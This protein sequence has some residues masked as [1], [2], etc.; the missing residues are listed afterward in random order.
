[1]LDTLPVAAELD[2]DSAHA[3]T[4][5]SMTIGRAGARRNLRLVLPDRTRA[6]RSPAAATTTSAS[7]FHPGRGGVGPRDRGPPAPAGRGRRAAVVGSVRADAEP[8]YRRRCG[9]PSASALP[10]RVIEGDRTLALTLYGAAGDVNWMRY[11]RPTPLVRRMSWEQDAADEVTLTLELDRPVWG[12]RTRWDGTTSCSTSAGLPRSTRAIRSVGRLIAVDPGHPPGG[13]TGPTGLR[14]A[15][16]NLAV[17][18]ELRRLLEAAGARVLMTRTDDSAV[19]LW[20]RVAMAERAD[21][22]V[23]VSIHNNALP[24]GVNPFVN[25]GRASTTTSPAASRSRGPSRRRC[26][27][28]AAARPR[29]RPGRPGAGARRPGC[30]RC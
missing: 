17:A 5:D 16:A 18:L 20:P 7:G 2:D 14:E 3:G 26:P 19:D 28:A 11:G 15:E 23:L 22:D 8:A 21:A 13:A 4:T 29:H 27:P 9:C 6:P 1:M 12:Y 24:D 30:P 25:N 10:F